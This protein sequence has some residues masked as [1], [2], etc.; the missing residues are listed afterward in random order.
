V[1]VGVGGDGTLNEITNGLLQAQARVALGAVPAGTANDFVRSMGLPSEP[2]KA[3]DVVL[4]G[5][6][7]RTD[8]GRCGERYF[9][10]GGGA[11]LD[12]QVARTV[13]RFPRALK[14]GAVPYVVSAVIELARMT[15]HHLSIELDDQRLERRA[16]LV[17]VANGRFSGGGMMMCPEATCEDGLLDVCILG[18][19][20]RREVIKLLL[21][22]F[23]GAHVEHPLVELHRTRR[24]RIDSGSEAQVQVDGELCGSL[25]AVFEAVPAALDVIVPATIG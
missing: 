5:V 7:R 13:Q 11:G 17:A 14:V 3:L 1:V 4:E 15:A 22:V 23:S 6:A 19:M 8:L 10:N 25:P 21:K 24:L 9:L 18:D 2:T 12:A 20:P 16:L